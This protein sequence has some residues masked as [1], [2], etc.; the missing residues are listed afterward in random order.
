[1]R[2]NNHASTYSVIHFVFINLDRN[3]Q[4]N[5]Y[6]R[7]RTM[8]L[9]TCQ[10]FMTMINWTLSQISAITVRLSYQDALHLPNYLQQT[11]LCK[12]ALI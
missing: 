12:E 2:Q 8:P 1:M 3:G 9:I 6:I 7:F 10:K 4:G 5:N 11:G